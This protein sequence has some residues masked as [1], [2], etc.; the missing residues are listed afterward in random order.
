MSQ[1]EKLRNKSFQRYAP[2]EKTE[3]EEIGCVERFEEGKQWDNNQKQSLVKKGNIVCTYQR[4][5]KGV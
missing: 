5:L 1:E 4:G 3:D 2:I